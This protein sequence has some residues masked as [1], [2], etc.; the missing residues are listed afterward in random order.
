LFPL[1]SDFAS[2]SCHSGTQKKRFAEEK[3]VNE[4]SLKFL[5]SIHLEMTL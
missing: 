4:F 5:H 2:A 3:S 1:A